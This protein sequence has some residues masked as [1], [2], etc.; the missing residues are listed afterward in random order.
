MKL[1]RTHHPVF[2]I[3]SENHII[4]R[5]YFNGV[6]LFILINAQWI[7][8]CLGTLNGSSIR[9]RVVVCV[10]VYSFIYWYRYR[11]SSLAFKSAMTC[12][13]YNTV[14]F[15]VVYV[16]VVFYKF[17]QFNWAQLAQKP[18]HVK[19]QPHSPFCLFYCD[20]RGAKDNNNNSIFSKAYV[21]VF[22]LKNIV[23]PIIIMQNSHI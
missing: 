22:A 14:L 18:Y 19:D 20:M 9:R 8:A 1:T 17:S 3:A 21:C 7:S 15:M 6:L 13:T 4:S 12:S 23:I 16:L 10:F 2:R 5:T 11:F